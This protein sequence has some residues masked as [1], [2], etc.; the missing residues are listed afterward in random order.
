M[1][2]IVATGRIGTVVPGPD[3]HFLQLG[4]ATHARIE[5]EV[6]QLLNHSCDPNLVLDVD[7]LTL[8]ALRPSERGEE[9]TL[10]YPATE[11]EM[12]EPFAC[13][14]G[15]A[16]CVGWIAGAAHLPTQAL[17]G[18]PLAPHIRHNLEDRQARR[19]G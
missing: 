17:A 11:W 6:L 14:C 12:A 13:R 5:P 2:A 16:R 7:R 10:F 1:R 9:L 3:R 19:S 8:T 18:H 15:T 4:G